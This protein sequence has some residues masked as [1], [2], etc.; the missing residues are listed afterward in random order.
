M[1]KVG[2]HVT[3]SAYNKHKY[4]V[5]KC[6]TECQRIIGVAQRSKFK[7]AKDNL[8]EDCYLFNEESTDISRA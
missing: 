4:T 5:K 2:Q 3:V 6:K 7:V 1:W 8:P